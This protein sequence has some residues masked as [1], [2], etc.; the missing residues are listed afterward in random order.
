MN[1]DSGVSRL[2]HKTIGF[3]GENDYNCNTSNVNTV[4]QR[5]IDDISSNGAGVLEWRREGAPVL[6]LLGI[7]PKDDVHINFNGLHILRP[8]SGVVFTTTSAV[9]N[10]EIQNA[11]FDDEDYTSNIITMSGE[12]TRLALR[13][14]EFMGTRGRCFHFGGDVTLDAV[15]GWN[16]AKGIGCET[17]LGDDSVNPQ[18]HII[19]GLIMRNLNKTAVSEGEGVEINTHAKGT[20]TFDYIETYGYEEDHLDLNIEYIHG[21]R[22]FMEDNP[23]L[24]GTRSGITIANNGGAVKGS[25]A[26]IQVEG[27]SDGFTAFHQETVQGFHVG[28]IGGFGSNSGTPEGRLLNISGG[29]STMMSFGRVYGQDLDVGLVSD[30]QE[31]L[32]IDGW[33]MQNVTTEFSGG[34]CRPLYVNSSS[35]Y[36]NVKS[37]GADG[38]TIYNG[39]NIKI[40]ATALRLMRNDSTSTEKIDITMD[41]NSLNFDYTQDESDSSAHHLRFNIITTATGQHDYEFRIN[42]VNMLEITE[43]GIKPAQY[44]TTERNALT[45]EEGAIIYN[46]TTNKLNVYTGSAWEEVTSS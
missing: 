17:Y 16:V 11:F 23:S 1:I 34:D 32:M 21:G 12:N 38:R 14:V 45:A 43:S 36:L 41:D 20:L 18:I 40:G 22:V 29:S 46:T 5:A 8:S 25:I 39:L 15:R 30:V 7:V 28:Y 37:S 13:R 2:N 9:D 10:F 35:N 4:L 3:T 31:K 6:P 24:S 44:T 42:S 19:N 26:H 27:I 33:H